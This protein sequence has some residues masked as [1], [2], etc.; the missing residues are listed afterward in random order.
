M[1][2]TKPFSLQKVVLCSLKL[3]MRCYDAA[4]WSAQPYLR[5]PAGTEGATQKFLSL[6]GVWS[7]ESMDFTLVLLGF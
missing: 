3:L 2:V 6:S 1:R 5:F 7:I 4:M